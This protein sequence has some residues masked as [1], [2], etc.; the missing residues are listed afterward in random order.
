MAGGPNSTSSF[1]GDRHVKNLCGDTWDLKDCL[2]W[3]HYKL[4]EPKDCQQATEG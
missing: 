4:L 3:C 1:L 2:E